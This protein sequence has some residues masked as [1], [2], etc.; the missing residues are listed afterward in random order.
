[1]LSNFIVSGK[2]NMIIDGQYGSTG[3]GAIAARIAM[4]NHIDIACARLSPNAGHTFYYN[5]RKY[6]TKLFPVAGIIAKRNTIYFGPGS[7]IN[8]EIFKRELHDFDIDPNRIIIHPRTAVITEDD[9]K[10]EA[11]P[12]GIIKIA[13]TQS[14]SGAARASKIMRSN[15][16]AQGT[17]E[18]QKYL[19]PQFDL[20]DYLDAGVSA[21][22]E[23]GQGFDLSIN[24]GL[25]YPHCTSIDCLPSAILADFCLHPGYLGNIMMTIRTYPI[26]VGNPTDEQGKEIGESGPIYKD[27]QECAWEQLGFIPELT[28]VTKRIRRIFTFSE[29]QY[30][31]ALRLIKPTHIFLN[32]I[33]YLKEEDLNKFKFTKIP[34]PTHVGYGPTLE[35][36]CPWESQILQNCIYRGV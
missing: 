9:L 11:E 22:A 21:L 32:F 1:M 7:V 15:P 3:K 12:G 19:N 24:A 36:I 31:R 20:Q 25:D 14:G 8:L 33:N 10:M 35:E 18:L 27:S 4:D 34:C 30:L 26:R 29:I 2:L 13:S 28:T 16:L 5:D 23:T 6:V 17:K